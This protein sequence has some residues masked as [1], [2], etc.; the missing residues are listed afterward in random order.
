MIAKSR[1]GGCAIRRFIYIYIYI[2]VTMFEFRGEGVFGIEEKEGKMGSPG[3]WPLYYIQI[4]SLDLS[5]QR[6]MSEN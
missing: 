3:Y 1:R 6:N 4:R 2:L 5:L